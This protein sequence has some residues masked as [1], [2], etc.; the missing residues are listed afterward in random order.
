M[1]SFVKCKALRSASKQRLKKFHGTVSAQTMAEIEQ[2][3][4][5]LL[6]L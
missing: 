5:I 1:L 2:R 4:R 3:V 6:N